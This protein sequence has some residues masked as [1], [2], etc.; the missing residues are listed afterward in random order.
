MT[1]SKPGNIK[2]PQGSRGLNM[3]G[4]ATPPPAVDDNV[5]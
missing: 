1:Y 5:L 2:G 4:N 3:T